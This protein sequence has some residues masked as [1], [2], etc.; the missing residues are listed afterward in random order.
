[1]GLEPPAPPRAVPLASH[2]PFAPAVPFPPSLLLPFPPFLLPA[3]LAGSLVVDAAETRSL[4]DWRPPHAV[5]EGLARTAT[6]FRGSA[7]L[8][9]R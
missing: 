2:D 9:A 1:M 7:K 3:K 5:D 4:L 6:W 8:A